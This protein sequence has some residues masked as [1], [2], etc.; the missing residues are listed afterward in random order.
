MIK[1]KALLTL[2]GRRAFLVWFLNGGRGRVNWERL[3]EMGETLREIQETL[4][5]T[6]VRFCFFC[7]FLC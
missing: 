2:N 7:G 1:E 6:S 3:R 4:R 5:A